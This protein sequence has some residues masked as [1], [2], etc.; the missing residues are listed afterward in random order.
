MSPRSRLPRFRV[1]MGEFLIIVAGVLI[2]LLVDE[3]R[4][5]RRDRTL[6]IQYASRLR[7]DLERDTARFAEFERGPLKGK[8]EVLRSLLA[9]AEGGTLDLANG[10]LGRMEKLHQSQYVALPETQPAVFRE[11]ESTGT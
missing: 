4:S 5:D 9:L 7:L 2:A 3:W 1:A 6:E 11:M 8:A 10:P